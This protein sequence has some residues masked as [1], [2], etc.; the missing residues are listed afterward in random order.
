MKLRFCD[1]AVLLIILA[2]FIMTLPAVS[3]MGVIPWFVSVIIC[4]GMTIPVCAWLCGWKRRYRSHKERERLL[5]L[6]LKTITGRIFIVSPHVRKIVYHANPTGT[7]I[8][9]NGV[10]YTHYGP[11]TPE[12][13]YDYY[14]AN[15]YIDYNHSIPLRTLPTDFHDEVTDRIPQ[16]DNDYFNVTYV[17]DSDGINY[18]V[19][20]S[21]N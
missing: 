3:N 17:T 10:S 5:G 16:S 19:S 20:S 8:G 1:Y 6:P 14:T 13:I 7:S 15:L 4:L 11:D 12:A 9:N 21:P 2:I 18:Y